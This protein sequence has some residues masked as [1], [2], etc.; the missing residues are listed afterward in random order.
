M[1]D[2][3]L[4]LIVQ[5]LLFEQ[6]SFWLLLYNHELRLQLL[7]WVVFG[8]EHF[9]I[10]FKLVI[11][12]LFLTLRS[13]DFKLKLFIHLLNLILQLFDFEFVRRSFRLVLILNL[14]KLVSKI[15]NLFVFRNGDRCLNF[16]R[17]GLNGHQG[18]LFLSQ[19]RLK[20][21][22]LLI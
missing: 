5:H 19:E 3:W 6:D 12:T 17:L 11:P 13:I 4:L 1:F 9:F 7:D 15:S 20:G 14:R 18:L 22:F 8:R 2:I 16:R 10:P 21:L